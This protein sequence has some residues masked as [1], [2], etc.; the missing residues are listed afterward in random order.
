MHTIKNPGGGGGLLKFL[1]KSL[2]EGQGFQE[3]IA[4]GVPLFWVLLHFY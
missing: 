1:P 4:R 3:K 2:G